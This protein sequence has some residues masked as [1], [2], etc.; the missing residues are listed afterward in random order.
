MPV[1][2]RAVEAH[3]APGAELENVAQSRIVTVGRAVDVA[4]G[5]GAHVASFAAESRPAALGGDEN[6]VEHAE[7]VE[8]A[9][10]AAQLPQPAVLRDIK[11][12]RSDIAGAVEHRDRDRLAVSANGEAANENQA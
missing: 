6:G 9:F 1:R 10:V 8:K 2:Q 4:I 5:G 3:L 11:R 12:D 7:G